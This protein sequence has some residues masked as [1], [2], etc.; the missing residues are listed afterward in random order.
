MVG[1]ER[2]TLLLLCNLSLQR[3][4]FWD[5]RAKSLED[6][7]LGP[8]ENPAEMNLPIEEAL[9]RL[10]NSKKYSSYFKKIFDSGP[11]R[12]NLAAAIAA[13][14]R[15]LETSNSPF[16]NWKYSDNTDA[17][18]DAVKRGFSIFNEKGKCIKCHFG[19]DFTTNQFRNIG[20]FNGR[21][22]NDSGRAVISGSKEDLRKIQSARSSQYCYHCALHAQWAV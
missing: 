20:L 2:G 18:D 17:V 15:T 1:K 8:I 19:A 22:L 5:G 14:E 16:D 9:F 7:V 11:T 21:E 6:Q 4:F 3:I 13:F 10:Q 12:N